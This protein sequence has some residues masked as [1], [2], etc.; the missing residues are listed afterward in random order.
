[1][2]RLPDWSRPFVLVTSA[3]KQAACSTL[4]Q[5]HCEG[6]VLLPMAFFSNA[7]AAKKAGLAQHETGLLAVYWSFIHFRHYLPNLCPIILCDHNHWHASAPSTCCHR[8]ITASSSTS[9]PNLTAPGSTSCVLRWSIY[10][11][12]C[13][14]TRRMTAARI[15]RV[16][17]AHT[18]R[19]TL[20]GWQARG[21]PSPDGMRLDDRRRINHAVFAVQALGCATIRQLALPHPTSPTPRAA[22][23]RRHLHR[24]SSST[25][26]LSRNPH[27]AS[28]KST[29]CQL[30]VHSTAT[31]CISVVATKGREGLTCCLLTWLGVIR[32]YYT[33]LMGLT[34]A[35]L[36]RL[37]LPL[38]SFWNPAVQPPLCVAMSCMYA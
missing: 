37:C 11:Q 1:M 31:S 26:P 10:C 13:S 29:F 25:F 15:P 3:S 2:L 14:A 36:E 34:A 17:T 19:V 27:S 9:S 4:M 22:P 7:P 35:Q 38:H 32:G 6:G 8:R 12:V 23:S 20:A 28:C 33:L 5:R 21:W 16:I 30:H 18:R 24:C